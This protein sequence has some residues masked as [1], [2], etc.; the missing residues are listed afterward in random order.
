MD[1]PDNTLYSADSPS[2][3]TKVTSPLEM[4]TETLLA[5]KDHLASIGDA[6]QMPAIYEYAIGKMLGYNTLTDRTLLHLL[7]LAEQD[8][9]HLATKDE[10]FR[11]WAMDNA[12][13]I[14]NRDGQD[15]MSRF[16]NVILRMVIYLD[17]NPMHTSKGLID[18]AALIDLAYPTSLSKFSNAFAEGDDAKKQMLV[19]ALVRGATIKDIKK[20]GG[21]NRVPPIFG[22]LK[23]LPDDRSELT[24]R[25]MTEDQLNYVQELLDQVL[26]IHLAG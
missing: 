1:D 15:K 2:G 17:K 16:V 23:Y 22:L 12:H 3:L 7:R 13:L 9:V 24:L 5:S 8:A 25:D 26:E 18:G 14:S 10:D 4:A 6:P 19:D 11:S 21:S 20:G